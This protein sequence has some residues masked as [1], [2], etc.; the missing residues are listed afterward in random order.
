MIR[1][2]YRYTNFQGDIVFDFVDAETEERA[3]A[4]VHNIL[5]LHRDDGIHPADITSRLYLDDRK[6][7]RSYE[8]AIK[9]C[10][11]TYRF[12][13]QNKPRL[14]CEHDLAR[15]AFNLSVELRANPVDVF[16]DVNRL[17]VGEANV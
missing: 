5:M 8:D 6:A 12:R 3:N 13:L 16:N 7:V 10:A 9:Q 15:R 17:V 4:L 11:E 14:Q 1:K 2:F